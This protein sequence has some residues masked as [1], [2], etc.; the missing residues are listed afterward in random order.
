MGPE[1]PEQE[2]RAGP[3]RGTEPGAGAQGQR[4]QLKGPSDVVEGLQLDL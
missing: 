2:L 1:Q 4:G 3:V